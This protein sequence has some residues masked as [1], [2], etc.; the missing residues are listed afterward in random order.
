MKKD[1]FVAREKPFDTLNSST[2]AHMPVV[3][4]NEI[5]KQKAKTIKV[6]T[7]HDKLNRTEK[8]LANNENLTI[9]EFYI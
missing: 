8:E 6:Y 5:A 3:T 9:F 1:F 2:V 4:W 7:S